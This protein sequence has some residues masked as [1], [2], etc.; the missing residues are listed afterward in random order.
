MADVRDATVK[1]VESKRIVWKDG[2]QMVERETIEY[3]NDN[4]G[5]KQ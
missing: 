4:E 3:T 1:K 2:E 5:L